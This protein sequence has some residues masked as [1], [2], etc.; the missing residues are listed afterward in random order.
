MITVTKPYIPNYS[1]FIKYLDNI[2]D[3][4]VLTNNGPLV[5]Q[6]EEKLA[7]FL[8]VK[9]LLLVNNGT[10]AIQLALAAL[11]VKSH[12]ITTPFSF[13]ATLTP[14][15]I[16]KSQ[17][18]FADI[19]PQTFNIDHNKIAD[20]IN[21]GV[22]AILPVHVFGNPCE[23]REIENLA[24][25]NNL[26]LIFD[27]SHCF[28]TKHSGRS[29]LSFGDIST[30]SFHAT[31]IFHTIEG[32]ALIIRD[33]DIYQKAKAMRNFGFGKDGQIQEIGINAKMSEFHAAMGLCVLDDIQSILASYK[34]VF[35][36]YEANL[37]SFVSFQKETGDSILN[38]SYAPILLENEEQCLRVK[39]A[40]ESHD[41]FARRYFYPS[42]DTLNF[43]KSP[44]MEV[45]RD[46]SSRILCLPI[47]THI[48]EH[49]QS[50]ICKI[51]RR[52]L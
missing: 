35:L 2:F 48:S 34:S 5:Q 10:V 14:I 45:S 32:G 33:D 16:N 40:L 31:K 44:F 25:E 50:I 6:L 22:E 49:E 1:K 42:L 4:S 15:L 37:S 30:L 24:K 28:N 47:S 20:L 51:V 23:C 52:A 27:A 8:G 12:V 19:D 46:V 39:R 21:E 3:N 18:I 43:V 29:L 17:P 11:D 7:V 13:I 9:N 26:K 41:I 38:Y 36:N